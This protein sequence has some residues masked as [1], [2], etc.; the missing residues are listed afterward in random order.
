MVRAPRAHAVD[1]ESF[2]DADA[3]LS[4]N[5]TMLFN[6]PTTPVAGGPGILTTV[7]RRMHLSGPAN[8]M[9]TTFSTMGAESIVAGDYDGF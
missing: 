9:I 5:N 7:G 6:S 1:S 2:V 4:V 8:H 3:P